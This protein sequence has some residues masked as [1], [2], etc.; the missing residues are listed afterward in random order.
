LIEREAG[1]RDPS[2][3][4]CSA[5]RTAP[6]GSFARRFAFAV[7]SVVLAVVLCLA[8]L[9]VGLRVYCSL[10]P[11]ADVEFYRY[12]KLMKAS[13]PGSR[14]SFRHTPGS[15]LELFGVDV[16]INSLGFRDVELVT[17]KPPGTTRLFLLGDSITFG[18]GVP[19]GER[20]S[21]ILEREWSAATGRP[22]ELVNTG[23]G[24]YNTAQEYAL[25]VEEL[26]HEACDGLLQVWYINDAEPTPPHRVAPW[27]T[28]FY[29]AIFLWAKKDL[30]KRRVGSR[31]TYVDYYCDLY[32]K[33]APGRSAFTAALTGTGTWARER[34]VPWVFVVL[35]EFHDFD[36]GG[37]FAEVYAIVKREAAEAGAIVVDS[38]P[39]F[40]NLEP[41]TLWVAPNDVHPNAAGHAVIARA[42]L[43][44]VS[45]ELFG[46]G[47]TAAA[48]GES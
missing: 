25:L 38:V 3:A 29:T 28:R 21:E 9:E 43:E 36:P 46:R 31:E 33:G 4:D 14:V 2:A 12:A 17:P 15:R 47:A 35:P 23:H 19:Y 37:P 16:S 26:S 40:A 30:L 34:G 1:K 27:Y 11:N 22:F 42:I 24:N 41:S 45:P 18:W 13:A 39:A 20:F 7:V 8:L 32:T 48:G 5:G 44:S 6:G 10:Q